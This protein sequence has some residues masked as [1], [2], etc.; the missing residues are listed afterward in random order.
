[1]GHNDHTHVAG[2]DGRVWA[3]PSCGI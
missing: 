2:G 3:A 1:P